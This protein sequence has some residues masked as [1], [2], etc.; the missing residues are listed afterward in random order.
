MAAGHGRGFS[1]SPDAGADVYHRQAPQD[2]AK[3]LQRI[4]GRRDAEGN[5]TGKTY[6]AYRLLYNESAH[7]SE[8]A[9][10][11]AYEEDGIEELE[12]VTTLDSK[13]CGGCGPRDGKRVKVKDAAE[14]VNIPAVSC[15]LPLY[16]RALCCGGAGQLYPHQSGQRPG[17]GQDGLRQ[18]SDI[19]GMEER[20]RW[21]ASRGAGKTDEIPTGISRR[22]EA[23]DR[24]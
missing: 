22:R 2:F 8:Q 3:E 5:L 11:A 20:T 12:I 24:G 10:L 7:V 15:Q 14:G 17:D 1:D 19:R 16:Y 9:K 18:G 13:T 23:K 4:I 6:E 21:R